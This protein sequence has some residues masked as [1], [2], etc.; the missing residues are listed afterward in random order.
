M[1]NR[2][3]IAT[4]S[5][6]RLVRSSS[7]LTA[8]RSFGV[9][10]VPPEIFRRAPFVR[11]VA[12]DPLDLR[13]DIEVDLARHQSF[14][15]GDRRHVLDEGPKA[16][17]GLPQGAFHAFALSDVDHAALPVRGLSCFVEDHDRVIA[18]PHPVTVLVPEP[19]FALEVVV[20]VSSPRPSSS[21]TMSRSSGWMLSSQKSSES[22]HSSAVHPSIDSTCGLRNSSSDS[23]SVGSA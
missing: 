23:S 14:D 13:A 15:V 19:V 4:G 16:H 12:E 1:R 3:S 5:P 18:Q 20:C 22:S 7:A 10:V 8:W 2:Y 6:V 9:H 11:G 21:R 17:L